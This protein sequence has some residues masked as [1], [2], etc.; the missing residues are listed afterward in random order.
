[1]KFSRLRLYNDLLRAETGVYAREEL[2]RSAL[3]ETEDTEESILAAKFLVGKIPDAQEDYTFGIKE[4]F[5]AKDL[6]MDGRVALEDIAKVAMERAECGEANP[7]LVQVFQKLY[8]YLIDPDRSNVRKSKLVNDVLFGFLKSK[9]DVPFLLQ[10]ICEKVNNGV[11]AKLVM[12]A[13]LADQYDRED[14][15]RA[16]AFNPSMAHW[17]TEYELGRLTGDPLVGIAQAGIPLEPQLCARV[18]DIAKV[19]TQHRGMTMVQPKLDGVRLHIHVWREDAGG[20]MMRKVK[21]FSRTLKDVTGVYEEIMLAAA[22]LPIKQQAILDGELVAL[23]PDGEV[24]PFAL[25]QTRLGR[26]TGKDAIKLGVVVYDLLLLDDAS[27]HATPYNERL[28]LLPKLLKDNPA[29]RPVQHE[30]VASVPILRE[31]LLQAYEDGEEGFVCKDPASLPEPGQRS[32]AWIKVKPDYMDS[33]GLQDTFDLVVIGYN[34]GRGRRHGKV[35][36]LWVAV[37]DADRDG[38]WPVSKVGT[39]L[40]DEDIDW[41]T[42]QLG[43]IEADR[44][45]VRIGGTIQAQHAPEVDVWVSPQYVI[46]VGATGGLTKIDKWAGWSLRFP[47]F[48]RRRDDKTVYQA[49]GTDEVEIP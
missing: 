5:L 20:I 26:K 14:I 41:W 44:P 32:K 12:H 36:A 21:L 34:K 2:I 18:D 17:I 11:D 45:D 49:T 4:A 25:L 30:M 10:I 23:G 35:G 48:I 24:A 6:G 15:T 46:E 43:A 19:L 27:I 16:F 22:R 38:F 9:D 3:S 40:S 13:L 33:E 31:K 37:R 8:G 47:R 29:L 7:S 42:E 28:A 1:M 39:G